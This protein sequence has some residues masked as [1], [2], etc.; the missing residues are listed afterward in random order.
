[1]WL[2]VTILELLPRL[3]QKRSAW[4]GVVAST[5]GQ[6]MVLEETPL[7]SDSLT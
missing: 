3:L 1:M 2:W 6:T 7:H 4:P 5:L